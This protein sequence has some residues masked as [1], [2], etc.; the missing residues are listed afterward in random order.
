MKIIR[1]REK[2]WGLHPPNPRQRGVA[3][4]NPL[5][6]EREGKRVGRER[7]GGFTPKPQTKGSCPFEPLVGREG[8]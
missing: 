4:L 7:V 1:I 2:E 5:L 6:G 3:P 8:R